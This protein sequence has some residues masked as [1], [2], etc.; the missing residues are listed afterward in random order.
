MGVKE[1]LFSFRGILVTAL[2]DI[3]VV[4]VL[5][6]LFLAVWIWSGSNP[7]GG[8]TITNEEEAMRYLLESNPDSDIRFVPKKGK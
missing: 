6:V 7:L 1:E 3:F 5:G 2:H 8:A 4:G